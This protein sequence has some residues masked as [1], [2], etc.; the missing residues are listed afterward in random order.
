MSLADDTWILKEYHLHEA[1]TI[2][3]RVLRVLSSSV[4]QISTPI[5]HRNV[6]FWY[7]QWPP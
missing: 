4:N 1:G 3:S 7:F 5:Y 2:R 6:S